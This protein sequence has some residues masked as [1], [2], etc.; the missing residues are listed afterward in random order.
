MGWFRHKIFKAIHF[1]FQEAFFF[2]IFHSN[3]VIFLSLSKLK[4]S[5]SFSYIEFYKIFFFSRK[6]MA[7]LVACASLPYWIISIRKW[8]LIDGK[9]IKSDVISYSYFRFFYYMCRWPKWLAWTMI[10]QIFLYALYFLRAK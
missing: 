9:E 1:F 6:R 4:L 2:K 7:V 8:D 5:S 3:D 10:G